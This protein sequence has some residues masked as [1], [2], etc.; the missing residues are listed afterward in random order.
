MATADLTEQPGETEAQD[1]WRGTEGMVVGLQGRVSCTAQREG[2]NP[3][4]A[5]GVSEG[6]RHGSGKVRE[7]VRP[8]NEG[9]ALPLLHH[10]AP[11][12]I[13]CLIP[14]FWAA[15]QHWAGAP[16]PSGPAWAVRDRAAPLAPPCFLGDSV[17]QKVTQPG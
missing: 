14:S 11:G 3:P 8:H 1:D 7:S 15:G 4:K 10:A 17:L 16:D 5:A 12:P 13:P 2:P 6:Q 9:L